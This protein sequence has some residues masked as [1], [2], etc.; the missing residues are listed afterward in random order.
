MKWKQNYTSDEPYLF[1]ADKTDDMIS[2]IFKN[3]LCYWNKDIMDWYLKCLCRW[4][5]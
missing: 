5:Q 3:N 1:Y 2:A 4:K